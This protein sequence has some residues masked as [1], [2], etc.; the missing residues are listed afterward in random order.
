[1]AVTR[2]DDG[3]PNRLQGTLFDDSEVPGV[4]DDPSVPQESGTSGHGAESAE[5]GYRGPTA[6]SAA[7]ITYRQLDYWARTAGSTARSPSTSRQ[8]RPSA[9]P[10]TPWPPWSRSTTSS[11][12]VHS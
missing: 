12:D 10:N 7:G 6:C 9:M 1:M 4:A 3:S 5:V 2:G 8:T 11:V